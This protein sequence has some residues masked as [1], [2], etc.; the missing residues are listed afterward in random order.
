MVADAADG[1]ALQAV[2]KTSRVVVTTVGPFVL[3]G[4]PLVA[5]CVAAGTDYLDIA[6]EA[7]FVDRIWLDHHDNA[8][9][10]AVRL[11]HGCGFTA[12]AQDL[13]TYFTVQQLPE[14]VPLRIE[15][16]VRLEFR[17][18]GGSC[19]SIVYNSA[20]SRQRLKAARSRRE[21]ESVPTAR[22]VHAVSGRIRRDLRLGGWAM[23]SS[24]ISAD[25]VCRTAAALD[26][27]GPEFCYGHYLIFE[28]L[29]ALGRF[30]FT[31]SASGLLTR[32]A[33]TRKLLLKLMTAG[34]GPT[35]A[36]R[37]S[38]WF[39]LVFIGY[40]GGRTVVTEVIGGDPGYGE[41]AKMLAE[42]ALCIAF[43][44]PPQRFG[45]LTPA[46][47]MGDAILARLKRAGISF[48]VVKST[49]VD[50][51]DKSGARRFH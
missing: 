41:T 16:Y 37:E 51:Q 1:K 43:G 25:T 23:P 18:S 35:E 14:D 29:A 15:G 36:E 17:L 49:A 48:Q 7:E 50:L 46:V 13:G 5:A 22:K 39:K 47:A 11:V 32:L 38:A 34:E 21:A 40:G 33:P 10:K 20:R 24:S 9:R 45:Q 3:Y 6:G 19:R 8:E 2:A 44:D 27:Y 4:E 42:S 31:A 28:R 12:V 26:S 30:T